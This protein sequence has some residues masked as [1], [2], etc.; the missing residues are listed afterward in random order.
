MKW[1]VRTAAAVARHRW[2]WRHRSS[3]AVAVRRERWSLLVDVSAII[4]HD[5]QT[6]IQRVVRAVW[7]E[8]RHREDREF[9]IAPVYATPEHG[10]CY[11]PLGFLEGSRELDRQPVVAGCG[12]MF[13]GLDLSAHLLPK[14]RSQLRGWRASGATIHLVVY[15]L[16]PLVRPAWFSRQT[17]AH[18]R[19]WFDVVRD[20]A[21]QALCISDQV[22]RELCQELATKG[23]VDRPFVG[24]LHLGGDISKSVP[25]PGI[26]DDARRLLDGL[27]FRPAILMVGT[28]E[29]RKGYEIAL[30]AFDYLWKNRPNDAPDL[31]IVGKGGWKTELLQRRIR[32]HP[33]NG[34]RLHW[35]DEVSD[36]ALCGFYEGCRGV[37]MASRAEGFGL[38]L[39]EAATHR[40]FIL[41]RD[42]PVFREQR[43]P[44]VLYFDDDRPVALAERLMDLVGAGLRGTAPVIDLRTWS[45]CVD[46]LLVEMGIHEHARDRSTWSTKSHSDNMLRAR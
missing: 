31:I 20:D 25:S 12:D 15:D 16:L 19:R 17:C 27:R 44:N 28:I 35:L 38:P 2:L 45:E 41:A 43:L 39:L 22:S 9:I 24:R 29:P 26:S 32:L 7:S 33:Q 23:A 5:A 21:D 6:G 11:A 4:Q 10:Y 37:L 36:E 40:R 42:L 3:F 34:R 8:L 1:L 14:Y 13:L 18:F 30:T 46:R